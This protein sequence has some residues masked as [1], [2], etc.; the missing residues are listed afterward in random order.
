MP[1]RTA[2]RRA[3]LAT[4]VAASLALA[5]RAAAA[6]NTSESQLW[7]GLF[8]TA[9]LGSAASG[10]SLWLD[11]HARRGGEAFVGILRPAVGWRVSRTLS[12]WT[13]YAWVPTFSDEAPSVHEHRAWQQLLWQD[14]AG[15]LLVQLRPRLE[16]RFR[17]AEDAALRLRAFARLNVSLGR[18]DGPLAIATWDEL[19]LQLGDTSW[20]APGGFDQNRLFLG[21]AWSRGD[22]RVEPGYLNVAVRRADG[23]MRVQHDVALMVFWS[24]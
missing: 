22:V 11:L 7:A 14:R 20:R 1:Q 9:K 5:P 10:P 6:A 16:Q 13:G 24:F 3:A 23:S 4:V 17:E 2:S 12:A 18:P 19:F 15:P 8:L 21:F